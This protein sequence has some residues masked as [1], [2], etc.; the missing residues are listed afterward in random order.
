MEWDQETMAHLTEHLSKWPTTGK[1]LLEVCNNMM[2]V[3][4]GDK[5]MIEK[6]IDPAKTYNSLDE[7]MADLNKE[8]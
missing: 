2:D 6:K 8:M 5:E 4:E 1:E 7:V 3:P